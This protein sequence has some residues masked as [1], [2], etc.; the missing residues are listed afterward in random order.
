MIKRL[1][2]RVLRIKNSFCS[3]DIVRTSAGLVR[4]GGMP[5]LARFLKKHRINTDFVVVLPPEVSMSGDNHAGEESVLGN[6][7]AS[8]L[9]KVRTYIGEAGDLFNLM[10]RV[11]A[12][13]G[14]RPGD[15]TARRADDSLFRRLVRTVAVPAISRRV[16]LGP[17]TEILFMDDNVEI[18]DDHD[19][20]YDLREHQSR[21]N[22]S[23]RME[24]LFEKINRRQRTGTSLGIFTVGA[25]NGPFRRSASFIVQYAGRRVWIDP[26]AY[27][28]ETLAR[29]GLP[30]DSITDVLVTYDSE[31][32]IAGLPALLKRARETRRRIDLIATE[33]V[34]A[35]VKS[36]F[37]YL[38]E[39][40]L[41][42]LVNLVK[43]MPSVPL[44]YHKGILG[45]RLNF[46]P[47]RRSPLGVKIGYNGEEIALSG[48]TCYDENAIAAL[49][50]PDYGWQWFRNSGIVF[51]EADLRDP[52]PGH[53]LYRE[54]QKLK[55]KI[56]GKVLIYRASAK[57]IFL[58]N[59]CREGVWY[60]P[61]KGR[62][63]VRRQSV[64]LKLK[65]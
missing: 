6:E 28:L 30:V 36:R 55:K 24:R 47:S 52:G 27:P 51:H 17:R 2:P 3:V 49:A 14:L 43:V 32:H 23:Y 9:P 29:Y 10:R 57:R 61:R 12:G 26:C 45:V 62:V 40:K 44:P 22:V 48:D 21:L 34:Y 39:N 38:F 42:K 64:R 53:S 1:T 35:S 20:V 16:R 13:V 37:G 46:Y 63:R 5:D 59:L 18:V 19:L 56:R 8:S 25:A 54:V 11:R 58:P 33:Q 50:R 7:M 60:E 15:E 41:D 31:E 65:D 4:V